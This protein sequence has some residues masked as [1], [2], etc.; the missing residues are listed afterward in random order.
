MSDPSS[1]D[2]AIVD[3]ETPIQPG[4]VDRLSARVRRITAPNPGAMTGPGT[5]TYLVGSNDD[6]AVIDP[7]PP[8]ESHVQAILAATGSSIARILVT[9]THADHS[10][11]A[12]ELKAA[13]GA[14][15]IGLAP[16]SD[17][18]Q[19][20]TF[21]PDRIPADGEQIAFG[22]STLR[23]IHT[24][25]HASNQICY[26]LEEERM[27]FTGDHI[28]QG[29]TVVIN[30]P[31]GDM[32]QYLASL[33]KLKDVDIACLAPGHGYPIPDPQDTIEKLLRHR[34]L[35]E[36]K[37]ATKLAALG[38]ATVAELVPAVYDDVAPFMHSMAARSLMAHLLKLE[39]EGLA[40]RQGER[41]RI[42]VRT[43]DIDAALEPPQQRS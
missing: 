13:T 37:I 41:W 4:R 32:A 22:Q 42:S 33:R 29:S 24:P 19:D 21:R 35:R 26:L 34:A 8:V 36:R 11:A 5:N 7:G 43:T 10:P 31:D 15:L 18:H 16:P 12:L 40:G 28:M 20:L 23:A 17:G 3:R 9:H 38:D 25:G 27:L 39:H 6:V 30:P 1:P 2:P 14:E